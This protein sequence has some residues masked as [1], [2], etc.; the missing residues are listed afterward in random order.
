MDWIRVELMDLDGVDSFVMQ[1]LDD[2][3]C[4]FYTIVI[5]A[6]LSYSLQQEA[7]LHEIKHIF[8]KDF[9]KAQYMPIS[10]IER[11]AHSEEGYHA[12]QEKKELL[13]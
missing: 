4:T 3:G 2:N 12:K 13:L 11:K 1:G 10:I 7:Y 8:S 5:N 9:D 6:R